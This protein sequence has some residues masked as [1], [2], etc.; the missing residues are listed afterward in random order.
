MPV[1]LQV[2]GDTF[3]RLCWAFQ[4]ENSELVWGQPGWIKPLRRLQ[5]QTQISKRNLSVEITDERVQKMRSL[6]QMKTITA[7]LRSWVS[8][9]SRPP[10]SPWT[11]GSFSLHWTDAPVGVLPAGTVG[12]SSP[13]LPPEVPSKPNGWMEIPPNMQL[14]L[15]YNFY[16]SAAL[17]CFYVL[18]NISYWFLL[19]LSTLYTLFLIF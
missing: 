14:N 4:V 13:R 16:Y 11:S 7:A 17:F 12:S 6:S 18:P 19:L 5:E 2:T 3:K 1:I 8:G 9:V 15:S 10:S